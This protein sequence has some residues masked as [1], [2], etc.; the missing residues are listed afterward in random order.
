MS[1]STQKPNISFTDGDDVLVNH[2]YFGSVWLSKAYHSGELVVGEVWE[3]GSGWNMPEDYSGEWT[4]M[5]FPLTCI[6][7]VEHRG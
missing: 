5:N 4:T 3:R 7:K 2:P 6:R 1:D